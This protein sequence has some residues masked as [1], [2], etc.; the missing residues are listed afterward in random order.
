MASFPKDRRCLRL[1]ISAHCT[2]RQ[3]RQRTPSEPQARKAALSAG[4]RSPHLPVTQPRSPHSDQAIRSRNREC[5]DSTAGLARHPQPGA[6]A[7]GWPIEDHGSFVLTAPIRHMASLTG[8]PTPYKIT[9]RTR[10]HFCPAHRG[11][12][13]YGYPHT[14]AKA[15]SRK[16]EVRPHQNSMSR[17]LEPLAST[18]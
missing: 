18:Q 4:R 9:G 14:H 6:L 11:V 8:H 17:H 10:K 16:N 7:P 13:R 15:N 5:R 12:M 3:H 1:T 2:W